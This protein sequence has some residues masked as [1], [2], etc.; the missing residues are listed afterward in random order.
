MSRSGGG[1]AGGHRM[2]CR[3]SAASLPG[4]DLHET[5]PCPAC[6]DWIGG[7]PVL[8]RLF[9]TFYAP[10]PERSAPRPGA[11]AGGPPTT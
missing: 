1:F 9:E 3:R 10:R 8:G 4:K 5:H 6:Y 11:R 7:M 2:T